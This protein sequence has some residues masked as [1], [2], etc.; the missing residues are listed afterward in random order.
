MHASQLE[1]Q[2]LKPLLSSYEEKGRGESI[3]FLNWFLENIFRLEAVDADDAICDRPNDRGIDGIYVDHTMGTIFVLQTKLKQRV[4]T[5]GDAPLRELAG[6]VTQFDTA[7]SVQALLD[8]GG[9]VELKTVL[10]RNNI[11][12]L[13]EKG[14]KVLGAFI[15]NRNID[16]NGQEFINQTDNIVV[17]D[18]DRIASE[19]IDIDTIGGVDGDFVFDAS[20]V[21]PMELQTGDVATSFIL[22]VQALELVEMEGIDD[23]TLFSQNVRLS[24]GNTKVNK[25]LSASVVDKA[26]HQNFPLYH[27]GVTILCES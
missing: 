6:T 11:K 8:G 20:Y 25:A 13:V 24:L 7:N 16:A 2:N 3:A 4:G 15:C 19:F 1:Y 23:G 9:N 18:P 12:A 27:N 14:Y 22:P 21:A 17:F 26:E 10:K 5:T